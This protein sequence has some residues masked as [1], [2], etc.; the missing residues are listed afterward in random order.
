MCASIF[1]LIKHLKKKKFRGICCLAEYQLQRW[2]Q[3]ES[4]PPDS[5][6]HL[7]ALFILSSSHPPSHAFEC[8]AAEVSNTNA[9][10]NVMSHSFSLSLSVL[11]WSCNRDWAR[12]LKPAGSSTFFVLFYLSSNLTMFELIYK[13]FLT[14]I[15]MSEFNIILKAFYFKWNGW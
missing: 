7:K 11:V 14:F 13:L 4:S 9:E 5:S 15:P 10:E 1:Y 12:E 8:R 3:R 2:F 6:F